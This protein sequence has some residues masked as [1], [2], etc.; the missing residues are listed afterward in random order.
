MCRRKMAED[1]QISFV[2]KLLDEIHFRFYP[3]FTSFS[4]AITI[5]RL[6]LYRYANLTIMLTVELHKNWTF[7]K[8]LFHCFF[9][10]KKW[11][12]AENEIFRICFV[13]FCINYFRFVSFNSSTDAR[14]KFLRLFGQKERENDFTSQHNQRW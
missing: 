9:K 10:N 4:E 11:L 8:C 5:S 2:S 6:H 13:P 7:K 1:F 3:F 12:C 14:L